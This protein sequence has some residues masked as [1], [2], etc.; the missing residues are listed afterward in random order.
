MS[1]ADEIIAGLQQSAREAMANVREN[2]GKKDADKEFYNT[3][4]DDDLEAVR[5]E[6][7]DSA[8]M[9]YIKEMEVR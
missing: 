7:G 6:I 3:L 2:L 1:V 5:K 4:T 8:T 9:D